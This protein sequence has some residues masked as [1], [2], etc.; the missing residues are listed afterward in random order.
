[1]PHTNFRHPEEA[2]GARCLEGRMAPVRAFI[3]RVLIVVI[4]TLALAGCGKKGDPHAPPDQ[5]DT[6]PRTYP[7]A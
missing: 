3:G 1:M 6:Y 5:P 2:R 7:S 4:V